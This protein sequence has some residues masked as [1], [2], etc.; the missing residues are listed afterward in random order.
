MYTNH[1]LNRDFFI[2]KSYFKTKFCFTIFKI[3]LNLYPK[4]IKT[5]KSHVFT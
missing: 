5:I 2:K 4:T 3:I 1:V